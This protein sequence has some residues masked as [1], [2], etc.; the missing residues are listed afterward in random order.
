MKS[1]MKPL[2][3]PFLKWA[4]GKTQ[5][6]DELV[7]RLPDQI[8]RG[9]IIDRYI[10][11]FIGGGA[12]FFYLKGKFK[13][14]KSYL[15]D[16]NKDL[17]VTYKVI[18]KDPNSL[19]KKLNGIERRYLKKSIEDRETYY[20]RI[21][22]RYNNQKGKFGYTSY[23]DDW[24]KRAAY[25]IFLNKTCF[26]GLYRLNSN[27]EFNVPFGRYKNPT[28]LD[29]TNV[30]E[31]SKALKN[32]EICCGDFTESRKFVKEGT[33]IYCD[34][35]YRPLNV[36]SSFTGFTAAGFSDEDQKRL[37]SYY[38]DMAKKKNVYLTLS[39]SDPQNVNPNDDFFEKLYLDFNI[40]KVDANRMIN[41][42]AKKRGIIKELIVTNC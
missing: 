23:N 30:L 42:D 8:K 34:P 5:L 17:V 33:L 16:T 38:K 3:K 14:R 18:Q 19:A 32:T 12:F 40:D 35:P 7:K 29:K 4:G 20:Y 41:C 31:V 2:A 22:K 15:I 10:E 1:D 26:N 39:N 21:R 11:P 6:L 24:V 37:A 13:I 27:G 25:L 36:T 28:I 9:Q